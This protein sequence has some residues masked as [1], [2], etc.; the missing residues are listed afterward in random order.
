[1]DPNQHHRPEKL[2]ETEKT[3][4]LGEKLY[5]ITHRHTLIVYTTTNTAATCTAAVPMACES[6]PESRS[7]DMVTRCQG[8][9]G[10]WG[11]GMGQ[12]HTDTQIHTHRSTQQQIHSVHPDNTNIISKWDRQGVYIHM[13]ENPGHTYLTSADKRRLVSVTLQK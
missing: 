11:R 1:M 13:L 9:F 8:L 10:T 12:T 3:V 7:R 4:L 6:H 5:A 2:N